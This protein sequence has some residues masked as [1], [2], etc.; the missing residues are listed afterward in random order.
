MQF[1]PEGTKPV[2]TKTK[3]NL[4]S[5]SAFFHDTSGSPLNYKPRC[6]KATSDSISVV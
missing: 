1:V 5:S 4:F 3:T 6:L 2:S